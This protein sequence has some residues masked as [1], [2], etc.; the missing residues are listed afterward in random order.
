MSKK[1]FDFCNSLVIEERSAVLKYFG[2]KFPMF[3]NSNIFYRDMQYGVTSYLDAKGYLISYADAERITDAFIEKL[4][5][6]NILAKI[7]DITWKIT[8]AEYN[9]G[10]SP[11]PAL[12]AE[13]AA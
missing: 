12:S 10:W 3:F 13:T 11:H 6:E 1:V 9:T 5:E 7:N 8:S 4:S 2:S